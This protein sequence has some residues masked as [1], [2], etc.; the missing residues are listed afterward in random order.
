MEIKYFKVSNKKFVLKTMEIESNNI[1]FPKFI[2]NTIKIKTE[3]KEINLKIEF[4]APTW[5]FSDK[6]EASNAWNKAC[7]SLR[8]KR[9]I[10]LSKRKTVEEKISYINDIIKQEGAYL[11]EI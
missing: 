11:M 3:E 2:K 6:L 8:T 4:Y 10:H 7:G 5:T 9:Y 1:E